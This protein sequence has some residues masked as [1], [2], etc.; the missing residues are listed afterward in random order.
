MGVYKKQ[1]MIIA[2][3]ITIV[4]VISTIAV[5]SKPFNSQNLDSQDTIFDK[6]LIGAGADTWSN[7][8]ELN[9]NYS[10]NMNL[11][12]TWIANQDDIH[13]WWISYFS[14]ESLWNQSLVPHLITYRYFTNTWGVDYSAANLNLHKQEWLDDLRYVANRLKGPNDGNHTVL[15]SLETEF[16]DPYYYANMNFTYWNELMIDSRTAIREIAPNILVSYCFGGWETRF[17]DDISMNG[18]LTS[19]MESMDFM[20]FQAMWGC[21]DAEETKWLSGDDLKTNYGDVNWVERFGDKSHV[22]DYMIDDITN[23]VE[24][25]SKYNSHLLLA[26]LSINDYLWGPQSQVDVVNEIAQRLPALKQMGLFGL[27]WM[28]Y[29]DKS[30]VGDGFLFSNDTAKPCLLP[31]RELVNS[32]G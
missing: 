17:N 2:L 28:H 24:A 25:L 3:F 21:S 14:P 13:G 22:W 12:T 5:I 9:S 31:W 20:S 23:N 11:A 4:I 6:F 27:S 7:L 32:L 10:L 8:H 16:N 18:A 15:I 1:V 29:I 19:S 26:H 30:W